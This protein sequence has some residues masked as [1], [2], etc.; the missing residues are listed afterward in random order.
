MAGNPAEY[1]RVAKAAAELQP[2]V[3]TFRQ[4]RKTKEHLL[5]TQGLLRESAG[6]IHAI[7]AQ[8]Q[9]P[10]ILNMLAK[11]NGRTNIWIHLQ[12]IQNYLN[13]PGKR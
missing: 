8:N 2:T 6:M 1:Q 11:L 5:D 13:W 3:E 12:V 9:W 7:P 4:V 10:N